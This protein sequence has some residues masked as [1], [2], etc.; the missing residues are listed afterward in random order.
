MNIY[1]RTAYYFI[2]YLTLASAYACYVV[3]YNS[4]SAELTLNYDERTV[5]M[6]YR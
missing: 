3:P 5:L 4:L 2:V 1:A 6:S